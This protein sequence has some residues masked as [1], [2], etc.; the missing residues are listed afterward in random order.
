M[1]EKDYSPLS[2]A[3]VRALRDKMPDKRK[4]AVAEIERLIFSIYFNRCLKKLFKSIFK[5]G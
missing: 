2:S 1:I 4:T 5:N 3:C